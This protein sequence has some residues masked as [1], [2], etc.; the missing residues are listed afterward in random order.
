MNRH[1]HATHADGREWTHCDL[2]SLRIPY[3]EGSVHADFVCIDG[4]GN[5]IIINYDLFAACYADD[6]TDDMLVV[7][8]G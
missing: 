5:P 1:W 8:D 7:W 2:E 6:A 4:A 3:G